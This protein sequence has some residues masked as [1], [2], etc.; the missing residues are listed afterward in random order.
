MET[1]IIKIDPRKIKLLEVNAR[2]MKPEE[3]E[4]LVSNIKKDG[5]LTSVPFCYYNE[6]NEIKVLSGNHRVMA[7]IDAGLNEIQ[8]MLC[9]DKL[10]KDKALAIQLSHNSI[11]GQDD[12]ELLRKLY[13]ELES[14]EFKEYSGLTDDFIN[15]CK[16][17]EKDFKIPNLQ[18]QAINLLFLPKEI[19]DI[20]NCLEDLGELL[21]SFTILANIKDYDNYLET[22]SLI[23]KCLNIKNPST[24][25]L[26]ILE[27]SKQN[28]NNLKKIA[29]DNKNIDHTPISTILGRSDINKEYAITIDNALNKMVD[30][31]IIKK[32]EKGKGLYLLAQEYLKNIK[33]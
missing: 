13:A 21:N 9:K 5:K 1:E 24:T 16:Q 4:K 2:Y 25:F 19:N 29:F 11:V 14:L 12:E 18:Y 8:V 26:S 17:T 33:S 22:S 31:R 15:F 6:D 27:L 3:Y 30:K 10:S 23:S 7:S 20:K 32:N 28:I